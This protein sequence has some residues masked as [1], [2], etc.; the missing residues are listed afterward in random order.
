MNEK[1][2]QERYQIKYFYGSSH[3]WVKDVV[4]SFK[5]GK[6]VLDIGPG[7][8][9]ISDLY[10]KSEY[11]LVAVEI[12]E[13]TR[14]ILKPKY[15][16]VVECISKLDKDEKYDYILL[17]DVLEHI[18]KP[19]EFLK[20]LKKYSHNE[21]Q[22]LISL[23]NVAH[24]SV[25]LPLFLGIFDYYDRGIMDKTHLQ[26]FTRKRARQLIDYAGLKTINENSTIEP[27]EFVLPNSIT[28]NP[29]FK[30]L[31]KLRQSLAKILPG[32]FA[33][34]HLMQAKPK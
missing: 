6:K 34:Q 20:N 10:P 17:L 24:W 4:K 18:A 29:I 16:S 33:Y 12:D 27:I 14:E 5:K 21:T 25:R 15:D 32:F 22:F 26:F 7:S 2:V 28:N 1:S 30:L 31:S 19:F 8:G 9:F 3:W 23:P 13:K 11:T